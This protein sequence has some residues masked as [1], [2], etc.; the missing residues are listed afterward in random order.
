[1]FST[2]AKK[3]AYDPHSRYYREMATFEVTPVHMQRLIQKLSASYILSNK[4]I[5]RLQEVWLLIG[6]K[7][8]FF[9]ENSLKRDEPYE[10]DT[11]LQA[12]KMEILNVQDVL[13]KKWYPLVQRAMK[14]GLKKG[15][16]LRKTQFF[17]CVAAIM[18]S[19]LKSLCYESLCKY[20]DAVCN[21]QVNI[22]ALKVELTFVDENY[23]L[24]PD[25]VDLV[26]IICEPFTLMHLSVAYFPRVDM[27]LDEDPVESSRYNLK[28]ALPENVLESIRKKAEK[29]LLAQWTQ[30][31]TLVEEFEE[32]KFLL[33]NEAQNELNEFLLDTD[34]KS[35]DDFKQKYDRYV[36]LK[37]EIAQL[38]KMKVTKRG[39]YV[40]ECAEI[41][42]QL[43][44]ASADLLTSLVSHLKQKL[45]TDT[46]K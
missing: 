44:S 8:S 25:I 1:M 37:H 33:T 5:Q 19:Q 46:S 13:Y 35:I 18:T 20:E 9:R 39:M 32:Y 41:F 4:C 22:G 17:N 15:I 30:A 26:K 23:K 40:I 16:I 42:K 3:C 12:V 28:T 31:L 11:Y 10:V 45:S 29:S 34:N 27:C 14:V 2:R 6:A 7:L 43:I 36:T 24:E 38:E 21:F